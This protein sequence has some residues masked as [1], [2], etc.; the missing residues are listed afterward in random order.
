[1]TCSD[2][3]ALDDFLIALT[4]AMVVDEALSDGAVLE[5][6]YDPRSLRPTR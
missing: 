1:M 3:G 6:A 2:A 5:L 4:D